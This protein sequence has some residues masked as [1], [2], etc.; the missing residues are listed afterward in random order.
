MHHNTGPIAAGP[1]EDSVSP[2][3]AVSAASDV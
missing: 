1:N 2:I 3:Q